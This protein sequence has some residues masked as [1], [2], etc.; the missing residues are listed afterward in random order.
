MTDRFHVGPTGIPN[1]LAIKKLAHDILPM[2]L[3]PGFLDDLR[4]R[5]SLVRLVG[6]KVTWDNRKSNAAKGDYWAPCPFH[7]ERTA[8]FHVDDAKGLYYCFG[9]HAKGDAIDFL[10]ETENMG[11]MEAVEALAQDAGMP[12]PERSK[13]APPGEAD[14]RSRLHAAME[15]AVAFYRLELATARGAE[16]RAY[17]DR[18]GLA[19]AT[20]E[21]FDIGYAPPGWQALSQHLAAKG[22]REDEL[23]EA[24]LIKEAKDGGRRYDL[25]RNRVIFPIRDASGRPIGLGGRTLE[26]GDGIPKYINSPETPLFDKGRTLFNFR[27]ARAAVGRAGPLLVTEGY[28]DVIAL[29]QAGFEAAVAPLGTAVTETQL[30]LLWRVTPEPVVAL[31]GDTAGLNAAHGLIDRALPL[32]VAGRSLRFLLLP[33]GQ[34][35][36][37]LIRSGGRA[38]MAALLETSLP[39]VE[40]LWRRETE[41]QPLDSPERRAAL[42]A[43]LKAH[44]QRIRDESL[45]GHTWAALRERRARLFGRAPAQAED[46]RLSRSAGLPPPG[47]RHFTDRARGAHLP[48][49]AAAKASLLAS[50]PDGAAAEARLRESA[51]LLGLLNNPALLPRFDERLDRMAFLCPDLAEVRDALLSCAPD[52]LPVLA[53]AASR[54]EPP[55]NETAAG[56]PAPTGEAEALIERMSARLGRD[57]RDRL[58]L[59]GQL[60]ANPHLAAGADPDRAAAAIEEEIVRHGLWI[61]KEAEIR[62]AMLALGSAA[63][64]LDEGLT[65]RLRQAADA[66]HEAARAG[67]GDEQ[68]GEN[69]AELSRR[70]QDMIDRQV[71]KRSR[72]KR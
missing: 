6:R 53:E 45:R 56:V 23:I 58:S 18:R 38:A 2:S 63:G 35:P 8:S 30:E 10:R 67:P 66:Q 50:A 1:A 21:R 48:A 20:R 32:L 28:T 64:D 68:T 61:E 41:G 62:E 22:F 12:M 69:A 39:I 19:P 60:R 70:L 17:L 7:Q 43:R 34:D 26:T 5:T 59:S 54:G 15:A 37:D 71:W 29:V 40:L 24:G 11:F 46:R 13:G 27:E 25:F 57:P 47:R 65:W 16:A 3:P 36:D 4:G 42:D 14:R 49:S 55:E 52:S 33:P 31:D 51:I 9:C 44:L 72:E